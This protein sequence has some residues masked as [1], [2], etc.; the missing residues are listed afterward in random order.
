MARTLR[1]PF[2]DVVPLARLR[3]GHG[4]PRYGNTDFDV[5]ARDSA[6]REQGAGGHEQDPRREA[7]RE[8]LTQESHGER[9]REG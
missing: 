4:L 8:R 6:D 7:R 1:A 2:C 5:S 9:D 3:R